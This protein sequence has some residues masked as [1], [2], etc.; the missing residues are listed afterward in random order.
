MFKR[1]FS[2]PAKEVNELATSH[3]FD[4]M[5]AREIVAALNDS[6]IYGGVPSHTSI[7]AYFRLLAITGSSFLQTPCIPAQLPLSA[8]LRSGPPDRSRRKPEG[9]S[10][11]AASAI[12]Q[13]TKE[14]AHAAVRACIFGASGPVTGSS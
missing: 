3:P 13:E 8:P 14:N 4:S 10:H 5:S 7:K 1:F 6:E 12:G 2:R 9:R 11:I